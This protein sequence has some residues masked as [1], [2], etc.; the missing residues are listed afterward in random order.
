MAKIE[1]MLL[2]ALFGFAMLAGTQATCTG[3]IKGVK[4]TLPAEECA[5]WKEVATALHLP[6]A[7]SSFPC[8]TYFDPDFVSERVTCGQCFAP[9]DPMICSTPDKNGYTHL[10][11]FS[12]E[13]LCLTNKIH[14]MIPPAIGKF[15]KLM[16]LNVAQCPLISGSIPQEVGQLVSLR[17]F[18]GYMSCIEGPIP[19]SISGCKDLQQF[20]SG[21]CPLSGAVPGSMASLESISLSYTDVDEVPAEIFKSKTLKFLELQGAKMEV[22]PEVSP[23][24]IW[25][26]CFFGANPYSKKPCLKSNIAT[27]PMVPYG[28]HA[29]GP[30]C[31]YDVALQGECMCESMY[32]HGKMRP[33]CGELHALGNTSM[34]SSLSSE[35]ETAATIQAVKARTSKRVAELEEMARVHALEKQKDEAAEA[36]PRSEETLFA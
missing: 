36:S 13:Y 2:L 32:D 27:G 22:C 23:S 4:G 33:K 17:K 19:S 1:H 24:K 30:E 21:L 29:A 14:G 16:E 8:A 26:M 12:L 25:E 11:V 28:L 34:A 20:R 18:T 15:K 7:L 35:A 5:A 31:F 9:Q 6:E 3:T 10:L